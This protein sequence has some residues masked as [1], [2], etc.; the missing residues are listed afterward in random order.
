MDDNIITTTRFTLPR[1]AYERYVAALWLRRRWWIIVVPV[2]GAAVTAAILGDIRWLIV[3]LMYIC[4]VIPGI[5]SMAYFRYLLTP[6]ARLSALPK[7]LE[8]VPGEYIK[9][10]YSLPGRLV[11]RENDEAGDVRYWL[12]ADETIGWECV[13]SIKVSGSNYAVELRPQPHPRFLLIPRRSL[14]RQL[15][16]E[17]ITP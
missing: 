15:P 11:G 8:I 5:V 12:P 6:E 3:A 2:T 16:F 17:F 4:I 14:S 1:S 10:S 13:E 9:V 7:E